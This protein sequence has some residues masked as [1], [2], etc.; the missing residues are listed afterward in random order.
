MRRAFAIVGLLLLLAACGGG[1]WLAARPPA[2]RFV[3]AGAQDIQIK[4]LRRGEWVISYRV[5][6]TQPTW[7]EALGRE[8]ERQG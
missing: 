6:A 1:A 5:A 2:V 7:Y 8:L 4:A 3:A